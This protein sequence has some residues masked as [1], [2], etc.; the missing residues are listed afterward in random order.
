M[1]TR[2]QFVANNKS[3]PRKFTSSAFISWDVA[4][5]RKQ[6]DLNWFSQILEDGRLQSVNQLNLNLPNSAAT[7]LM[8]L[9]R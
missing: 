3:I 5:G 9:G 6:P 1:G 8:T 7:H 4:R 2:F